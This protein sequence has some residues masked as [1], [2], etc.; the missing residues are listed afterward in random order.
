MDRAAFATRN[1][2]TGQVFAGRSF[3][4]SKTHIY[5]V[6]PIK[7]DLKFLPAEDLGV[8][9]ASPSGFRVVRRL[10]PSEHPRSRPRNE[11]GT[12]KARQARDKQA[13]LAQTRRRGSPPR[14][15][16]GDPKFDSNLKSIGDRLR[17]KRDA[18]ESPEMKAAIDRLA[19]VISE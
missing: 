13:L 8:H 17:A 5:E 18:N 15:D 1:L 11:L 3:G 4:N 6:A 2:L 19:K 12:K 16:S 7:K 10:D 14:R 9:V